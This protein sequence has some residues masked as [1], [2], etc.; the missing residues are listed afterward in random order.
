[1]QFIVIGRDGKD[2][3]AMDR[4]M[5]AR[6][7]HIALCDEM[8]AKGQQ[9]MGFALV[10][11]KGQMNGSAMIFDLPDRAALDEWLKRE[12]YVT[13]KVWETVEVSECRVG[14]SF[15]GALDRIKAK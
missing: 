6:P 13:G 11:D 7:A 14:P 8:A 10:D 1:M 12:P 15:Q 5:A 2:P 9:L 3:G 4:R